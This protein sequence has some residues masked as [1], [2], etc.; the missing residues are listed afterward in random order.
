MEEMTERK[1]KDMSFR[2][3]VDQ[4][5]A[6]AEERGVFDDLPG[7]GQP[8]DLSGDGD[9]T[10]KWLRDYVRR[11]G[12]SFEDALPLPLRLRKE[13]ERLTETA[14][15][16]PSE[17]A[18]RAAAADLNRRIL[19]WRRI[20]VGPPVYVKLADEEALVTAWRAA[21]AEAAERAARRRQQDGAAAAARPARR[22]LPW[23]RPAR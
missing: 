17:A 4:Q 11:E 1:P 12:A 13:S 22:W 18:L 3:W 19:D 9:F 6:D 16:F 8:L 15:A 23:R 5:I 10:G 7:A 14:A 2:T 21:R 20:P